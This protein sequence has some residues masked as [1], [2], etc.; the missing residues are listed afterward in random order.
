MDTSDRSFLLLLLINMI[1]DK[2]LASECI[3]TSELL[4]L[5]IYLYLGRRH[6]KDYRMIFTIKAVSLI[7]INYQIYL[8]ALIPVLYNILIT[9]DIISLVQSLFF[10]SI[11]IYSFLNI[12]HWDR[13]IFNIILAHLI[14]FNKQSSTFNAIPI[15]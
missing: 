15:N 7:I 4:L 3:W 14:V 6:V 5:Y 13:S 12:I 1:K 2:R 11:I 8:L 9:K 10:Q